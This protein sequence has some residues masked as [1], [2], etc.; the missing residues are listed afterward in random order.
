MTDASKKDA[1]QE[2][3]N[4]VK[5]L[6]DDE[7]RSRMKMFDNNIKEF[8]RESKR[9]DYD[10]TRAKED[11]EDNLSKIKKNKQLPWLVSNV[12]E[13]LDLEPEVNEDGVVDLDEVVEGK[14][15][16]IK[17][18]RRDTIFLPVPGLVDVVV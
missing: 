2:A 15:L 5:D 6:T 13:I 3:I 16:V 4:E 8:K 12:V 17:T 1:L 18:S 10:Y 7:I 9:L 11:V 14:A